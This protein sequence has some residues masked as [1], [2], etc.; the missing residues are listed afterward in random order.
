[1]TLPAVMLAIPCAFAIALGLVVLLMVASI[2][3]GGVPPRRLE[4][5]GPGGA[6]SFGRLVRRARQRWIA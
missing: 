2:G 1:M 3:L 5:G 4:D 6:Y